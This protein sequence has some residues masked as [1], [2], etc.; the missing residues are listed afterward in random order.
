MPINIF[1]RPK[2]IFEQLFE[3]L[4]K[5][6]LCLDVKICLAEFSTCPLGLNFFPYKNSAIDLNKS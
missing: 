3:I 4:I 6:F 2:R 5:P 1:Y